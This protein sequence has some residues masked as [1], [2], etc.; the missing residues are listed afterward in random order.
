MQHIFW[1][2]LYPERK[3]ITEKKAWTGQPLQAA[4]E[5]LSAA[6]N[7]QDI[8]DIIDW[9][10]RQIDETHSFIMPPQRLLFIIMIPPHLP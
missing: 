9:S 5:R 6:D 4:K 1:I 2:S 7:C 3:I 10:F 8:Y